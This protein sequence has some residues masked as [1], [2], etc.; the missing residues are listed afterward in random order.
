MSASKVK[1]QINDLAHQFFSA[2]GTAA[3]NDTEDKLITAV[4][5]SLKH[6]LLRVIGRGNSYVFRSKLSYDED[7]VRQ[8]SLLVLMDS[9]RLFKD[10]KGKDFYNFFYFN[11]R[12]R[13][14]QLFCHSN[15]K[16][17]AVYCTSQELNGQGI[18]VDDEVVVDITISRSND[19]SN[20]IVISITSGI[21]E[22]LEKDAKEAVLKLCNE[23]E[24]Q[25]VDSM[26][27]KGISGYHKIATYNHITPSQAYSIVN[28]VKSKIDK[29]VKHDEAC[30][31]R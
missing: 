3:K 26:F 11:L 19:S 29:M 31:S 28:R 18:S 21:S 20:D 10:D 5:Q 24:R 9:L 22:I 13:M 1:E 16:K 4:D 6:S 15:S 7:D 25:V 17:Y 23:K 14:H 27:S 30:F 8:E 12:R 2:K